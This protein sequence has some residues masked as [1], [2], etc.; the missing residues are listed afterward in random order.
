MYQ[1]YGLRLAEAMKH[2]QNP[3]ALLIG[4]VPGG[5]KVQTAEAACTFNRS[6]GAS[7]ERKTLQSDLSEWAI[8]L[9]TIPRRPRRVQGHPTTFQI[10]KF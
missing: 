8:R 6:A 10:R 2:G 9:A 1:L 7:V 5:L 4:R 3:V